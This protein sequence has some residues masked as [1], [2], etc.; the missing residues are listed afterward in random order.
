MAEDA[1]TV[2]ALGRLLQNSHLLPPGELAVE[3]T[4]AARPL[5]IS[6]IQMYL[7]DL[8]EQRLRPMDD[9][10]GRTPPSLRVDTTLAGRA[11]QTISVQSDR[12][13]GEPDRHRLWVPLLDGTERLGVMEAV[14]PG[15]EAHPDRTALERCRMLASLAALIVASKYPYSDTL[16]RLRR[17]R[18]MAV[19]AEMAWA[20]MPPRTLATKRVILAATLEP[21]YDVGGDAFDHSLSGDH[22]HFSI[23]DSVGHDLTAGLISSVAMA[24]CRASRRS[25][26]AL[27]D[28]AE[29]ADTAIAGQFGESRFATALLCDL[30]METGELRWIP[31]GH[32]PP[33]LIRDGRVL[34]QLIRDPRLPLGLEETVHGRRTSSTVHSENLRPGD[35]LLLFTDGVVEARAEDGRELGLTGLS[36]FVIRNHAEGLTAPETLRR[37]NQ[38]I[39]SH[40]HG[41]LRDDATVVLVEWMPTAPGERLS[42]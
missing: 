11:Y 8:R 16:A 20:F 40:Q 22:L 14:F 6:A 1:S 10:S 2:G 4:E 31:C 29:Q 26:G 28:A 17:R 37:L 5:G 38:A 12:V 35:R 7:V 27:A 19:Q 34:K 25:G 21:A 32:P 3:F 42:I 9:A 30:D 39:L 13:E 24:S 33:L 36:D 41:R 15:G 23:F 18:E